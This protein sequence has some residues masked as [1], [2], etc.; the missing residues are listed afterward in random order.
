MKEAGIE[1]K[2]IN[3]N[4]KRFQSATRKIIYLIRLTKNFYSRHLIKPDYSHNTFLTKYKV[5][6]ALWSIIC[7]ILLVIQPSY[8]FEL[9]KYN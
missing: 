7:L 8:D 6:I 4:I 1:P 9:Y 2:I 5:S 3:K